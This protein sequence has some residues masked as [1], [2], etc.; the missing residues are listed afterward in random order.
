MI[1]TTR[2]KN[3]FSII[4]MAFKGPVIIYDQGGAESNDFLWKIF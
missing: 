1:N 2:K 4:G 3:F